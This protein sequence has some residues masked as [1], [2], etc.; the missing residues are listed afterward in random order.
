[1]DEVGVAHQEFRQP[2]HM[3]VARVN[4][5]TKLFGSFRSD[6]IVSVAGTAGGQ[7]INVIAIPF[8]ARL[9]SPAEFGVWALYLV[10]TSTLSIV[11]TLRLDIPVVAAKT[12]KLAA[13]VL[14]FA[15]GLSVAAAL[16]MEGSLRAWWLFAGPNANPNLVWLDW[17]PLGIAA[18]A[19]YALFGSWW[20]RTN[21]LRA[22][23]TARIAFPLVS[24]SLQ[25][26]WYR[27]PNGLGLVAGNCLAQVTVSVG[28]G[29]FVLA[30]AYPRASLQRIAARSISILRRYRAIALYTTPYSLQGQAFRQ[31]VVVILASYASVA[32]SG[33]YAM[34]Q[35]IVYSP[36]AV[37]A[38]ALEQSI[39]PRLARTPNDRAIHKLIARVMMGFSCLLAAGCAFVTIFADRL[40]PL[41]MGPQWASS[42][43][44]LICM[45]YASASLVASS[46]IVRVFDLFGYQRL[47]L[48]VDLGANLLIIA[49]FMATLF[50]TKSP[51]WAVTALASG[52]TLYYAIWAVLAF[53]VS[54]MD[55][56]PLLKILL[57][58]LASWLITFAA[59]LGANYV[60]RIA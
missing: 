46:W 16:A 41:L 57:L 17:V 24:I 47:H 9:Y 3:T 45:T 38:A 4:S 58:G 53:H 56:A 33:S 14:L 34:A 54:R 12:T 25:L 26:L 55:R 30:E 22:V 31:L 20:L 29:I 60:I 59:C 49:A 19:L 37:V 28:M 7:L 35:R 39:Y 50:L 13:T 10:A 8:L 42:T 18:T 48:L 21:A 40:I 43:P 6:L 32:A 23:S 11:I 51:V 1:M 15:T 44:Y 36:L 52:M 5:R 27:W 2:P